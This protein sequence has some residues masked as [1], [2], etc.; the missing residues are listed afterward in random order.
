[1][2][3]GQPK[4]AKIIIMIIRGFFLSV[5]TGNLPRQLA[6]EDVDD[7]FHFSDSARRGVPDKTNS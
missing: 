4:K 2:L 1:M 6:P 5:Y 3:Q 7:I